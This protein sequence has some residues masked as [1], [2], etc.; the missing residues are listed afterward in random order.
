[1]SL[2]ASLPPSLPSYSYYA[3]E[4]SAENSLFTHPRNTTQPPP[5]GMTGT[6]IPPTIPGRGVSFGP[7]TTTGSQQTAGL[8]PGTAASAN[9]IIKSMDEENAAAALRRAARRAQSVITAPSGAPTPG[10]EDDGESIASSGNRS[11][12]MTWEE[13]RSALAKI[14]AQ[15]KLDKEYEKLL[16]RF[17]AIRLAQRGEKRRRP[18]NPFSYNYFRA[19]KD[20]HRDMWSNFRLARKGGV[21]RGFRK[22]IF[23]RM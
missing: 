2:P 14:K 20:T 15:E 21:H 23:R 7:Q 22:S 1:M 3:P 10:P 16:R 9:A 6:T 13:L 4:K 12:Q 11:S 18:R 5:T 8:S 19:F 17:A